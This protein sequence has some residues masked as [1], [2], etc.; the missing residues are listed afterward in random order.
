MLLAMALA[1]VAVCGSDVTPMPF[2][3]LPMCTALRSLSRSASAS[4][5]VQWLRVEAS[6]PTTHRSFSPI[7]ASIRA[8][9]AALLSR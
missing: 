2:G 7:N 8:K 6:C 9:Y 4:V 3:S 5:W 1:V